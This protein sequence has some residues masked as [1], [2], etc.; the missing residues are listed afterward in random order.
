MEF[1][2]VFEGGGAKGLALNG[3]IA[4]LQDRGVTFRHLVGTSAG[5]ITATLVSL[6]FTSEELRRLSL[7]QTAEGESRMTEFIGP[8]RHF[9]DAE[10]LSSSMG[11]ALRDIDVPIVPEHIE[12][13]VDLAVM[14]A[15]V[16]QRDFAFLMSLIERGGL[17]SADG[18]MAWMREHMDAGDRYASSLTFVQHHA[19]YKHELSLVATDETGSAMRVLNRHTTPDLPVLW[20]VRM[21]MSIPMFW[22]E[23]IWKARWGTYCGQD[24]TGHAMVD[25]GVVSN[26]ALRLLLSEQDWVRELMGGLPASA[27]D[28]VLGLWLDDTLDLDAPQPG[29][30]LIDH[31]G[32]ADT[33]GKLIGRLERL[34]DAM[35]TASDL[36]EARNHP[37]TVCRLPVKGY[38]TTEFHMSKGRILHLLDAAGDAAETWLSRRTAGG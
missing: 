25:G 30:A 22:P 20:G 26:F 37:S 23:V 36:A 9:T 17:F 29:A 38:G 7:E 2:V 5:A 8:P 11:T 1:D 32:V 6:G 10:M 21:S 31:L 34:L 33:H 18:F 4:A 27:E 28:Q 13:K 16:K 14:R 24:L 19:V 35:M 3:A 12:Q 15:L